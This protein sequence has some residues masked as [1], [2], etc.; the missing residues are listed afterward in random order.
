MNWMREAEDKLRHYAAWQSAIKRTKAEVRRLE[1]DFVTIRSANTDKT[2]VQG[3][4]NTR[5]E[6]M[7][8]NIAE[9]QELETLLQTTER[10]VAEVKKTLEL[11]QPEERAIL[12]AMIINYR[13]GNVDKVCRELHIE[14]A[15]AYRRRDKAL[16]AFGMAYYGAI[17]T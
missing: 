11:L 4:G 5:E 14:R 12:D 8:A 10:K 1:E 2:P 3:G 13:R 6:A 7:C 17:E 9:R 15:T 16:R